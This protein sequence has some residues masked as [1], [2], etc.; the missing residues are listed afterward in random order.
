MEENSV[1]SIL[2]AEKNFFEKKY[3]NFKKYKTFFKFHLSV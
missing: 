2:C 3:K 1:R